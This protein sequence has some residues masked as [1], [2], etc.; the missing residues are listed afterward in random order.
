MHR[1]DGDAW[2]NDIL[3]K[4][5]GSSE[6]VKKIKKV[7]DGKSEAGIIGPK[8]HVLDHRVYWGFNKETTLKL[9]RE[10]GIVGSG[11]PEFNFVAGSMFWAKPEAL[12]FLDLLP[13]SA[14]DFEPEPSPPDGALAHAVERFIGL[15]A[16]AA[17]FAIMEI[18]ELG[19]ISKPDSGNLYPFAQPYPQ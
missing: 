12:N 15:A 9:A 18:D 6:A 17:G 3:S 5:I 8:K 13:V 19:I 11:D 7:L 2:R 10:V 14:L 4:L 1:E 16:K